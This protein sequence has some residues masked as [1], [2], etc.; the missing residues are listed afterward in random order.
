MKPSIFTRYGVE[1][2]GQANPKVQTPYAMPTGIM[3]SANAR[4]KFAA[5]MPITIRAPMN[6][7]IAT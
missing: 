6:S 4:C 2:F 3:R 5:N 1:H 7:A